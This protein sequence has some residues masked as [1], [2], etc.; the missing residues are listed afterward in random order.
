MRTDN[1]TPHIITNIPCPCC[2]GE[3]D[4]ATIEMVIDAYHITERQIPILKT[5]WAARGM[6]VSAQRIFCA[7]YADDAN[8][9]PS[10]SKMY[11]ALKLNIMRMREK[12]AHS[13]LNIVSAGYGRGYKV[14]ISREKIERNRAK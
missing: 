3:V 10:E 6:P 8:G 12:L 2:G 5:L 14:E 9:G 11:E 1:L 7:M 4:K 13:N